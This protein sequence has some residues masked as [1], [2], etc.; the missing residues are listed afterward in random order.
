MALSSLLA[1][2]KHT[3]TGMLTAGGGQFEDWSAS[4]RLFERER[5][6]R[7]ALFAPVIDGVIEQQTPDERL[8]IM[9]DDTL[10]H[11]RGKK[12]F[13][14]GWKRDPLGPHFCSN[15]MWGQ[16]FLQTSAALPD[17]DMLG[18]ARAIPIDFKHAP[19][20]IK[21]NKR[22]SEEQ[23]DIYRTEQNKSRIS[24]VGSK[25]LHELRERVIKDK[26]IVCAVDGSFTNR[27]V[28]SDIPDNTVIIGRLRKDAC[29]FKAPEESKITCRGRRRFYGE[30]LS[31]P[32]QIRQDDTIQWQ[33]VEAF[34]AGRRH[35]F[36]V[37]VIDKVRW[38]GSREQDVRLIIIRPL[39]Y[40]PRIGAKL[41]YRDPAYLICSD[42]KLPLSQLLQAYLWRWEIELNFR[43]EKTILGVG[44]AG[45]RTP[46][47]V[48]NVPA[49]MV[50]SY[51]YL[52][53][54]SHKTVKQK[55]CL[56]SP[57]WYTP[58]STDR[59]STQQILSLFRSQ[60]WK[61]GMDSIL[62]HFASK[63]SDRRSHFN[64]SSSLYSAVCYAVK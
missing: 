29:L 22:A 26:Q 21:P 10:I 42:T 41:L 59:C 57:K 44:E 46:C 54:A 62:P 1:L 6:D 47:A 7:Q 14:T 61:I 58:K 8:F 33:T 24:L 16:R 12:V 48:Q 64:S 17:P 18:R 37:K 30:A 31:T 5:I 4:Y 38:K 43:D 55:E 56:P 15:F 39:A 3:V 11:K 49:L 19:C 32:E 27:T 13:G 28:F 35:K 63:S 52:L 45:V 50:A 25:K 2:G 9:M 36:E 20:P 34:A 53:L 40:R 51:A 23:W 60:L